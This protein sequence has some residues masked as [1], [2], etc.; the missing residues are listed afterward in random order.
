MSLALAAAGAFSIGTVVHLPP[1]D[2]L[3]LE[4][5]LGARWIRI[6]LNWDL[7]E[8]A[9]GQWNWAPVD[10]VV[11]AAKQ[12]GLR[13]YATL[14]YTPAWASTGDRQGDGPRNDVPV[15]DKYRAFVVAVVERYHDTIDVFGTWNEPNLGEFFEGSRQEWI[16]A[17]Y[18]P[19][20]EAVVQTCP[21]C[22]T[23][24]P[25]VATI[26]T[27]YA[28]YL[29]DGLAAAVPTVVSGHIYAAFPED[30]PTAGLTKDSF[31]N[32]LD[33]HRVIPGIYEG[34]LSIR[35]SA[36]AAGHDELPVWI[37]E[38]G[39]QAAI[40]DP[41]NLAAQRTFVQRTL[42]AMETRAWWGGTIFYEAS[43]EHPG[44][45]WPDVH[46][47]LAL[48]TA[49]PDATPLDDFERKPAFEYLKQR[50]AAVAPTTDAGVPGDDAGGDGGDGGGG[51]H[52]N[53]PGDGGLD[54]ASPPAGCG[55]GTTR[56]ADVLPGLLVLAAACRR[57]RA[58]ARGGARALRFDATGLTARA[59]RSSR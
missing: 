36:H 22:T 40:G 35:E 28:S 58:L 52:G 45:M 10:A 44:G 32:K 43:E 5:D 34:P 14:G 29:Q 37:T 8:P 46:W 19:C 27:A 12:R 21:T 57:R 50:L 20:L 30:D 2:T 18:V 24:G 47:G 17:V 49:D 48:R 23:A 3:D 31:Y 39:W 54:P 1:S 25:E 13:V 56:G 33:A 26:G 9:E 15:A 11:T 7:V 53:E 16:D 42:D 6:D 59:R 38:T 55:C 51:G 4:V 41:T